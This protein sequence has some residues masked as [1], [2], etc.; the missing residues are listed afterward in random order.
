M[1]FPLCLALD[2]YC[3]GHKG[4]TYL[5]RQTEGWHIFLNQLGK[6]EVRKCRLGACMCQCHMSENPIVYREGSASKPGSLVDVCNDTVCACDVLY[7]FV[8][9]SDV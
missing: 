4:I 9:P 7:S 6:Q 8:S 1:P 2:F 5:Q 3:D